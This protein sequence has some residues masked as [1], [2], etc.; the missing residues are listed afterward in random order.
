MLITADFFRTL[1][2]NP[3]LGREFNSLETRFRGPQAVILT[4]GLWQRAFASD[5]NVLGRTVMLDD[6]AYT[7]VGVLP[8]GFWYPEAVDAFV[9][10]QP[11]GNLSDNGMNTQMIARLKPGMSLRQALAGMPAVTANFRRAHP[12]EMS[13][14]YGGL[15]VVPYQTALVGDARI[16]LLLLFGAVG[17]LLLI[18][19]SNLAGLL[20]S[21]FA[22]RQREVAVRLSLGS[23]RGRLLQQFLIEN[24][25]LTAAGSLAGLLVAYWALHGLVAL[26]PFNLPAS[27]PIRLDPPVLLFLLGVAIAIGFLFSL[28]PFSGASR[29]DVNETLKSGS[30]AVLG[31]RSG[32][33]R[34]V[35]VV[36]EV[37]L[38]TSLL[39]AAG[40]LIQSLYRLQQEP[41]GFTPQGLITFSTPVAPSIQKHPDEWRRF[42]DVLL[43]RFRM[44]PGV[45]SVAAVNKLPLTGPNNLPSEHVGH[46]ESS[47][48]G[49]EVRLV[50]PS[51]FETMQIPIRLGRP[52]DAND[53]STASPVVLVNETVARNGGRTATQSATR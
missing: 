38:S 44:V 23:S 40:L 33:T 50:S 11:S 14:N 45:H 41:L 49:M 19:C 18:A 46:P 17:L 47:I 24:M 48:G 29:L 15:T 42:Q 10:L 51:Y 36:S 4:D 22:A 12:G 25:L 35:L 39:V 1:G 6:T 53:T 30:R 28:S 16:N 37:A 20:L 8:R 52:F 32:M 5:R 27:A 21:R 31:G 7:I 3:Q 26:I 34:T 9:P 13:R 2:I 43:E